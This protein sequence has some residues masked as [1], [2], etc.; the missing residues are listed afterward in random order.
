MMVSRWSS[1]SR[2]HAAASRS[3]SASTRSSTRRATS[4]A[5]VSI[6]SW[7][8][9][10]LCTW[11]A[12]SPGT[13]SVSTFTSAGTGLPAARPSRPS[14]PGSKRPASQHSEIASAASAGI[15]PARAS[16]TAR[17]PSASSIACSQA[18]SSTASRI[19]SG[20]NIGPK[21]LSDI[22]EPSLPIALQ[23]YVEA[24]RAIFVR[25]LG[26][27]R[28]AQVGVLDRGEDRVD[29]VGLFLVGKV[30]ACSHAFEQAPGKNRYPDVGRRG[31]VVGA[32]DDSRLDRQEL[33]AA[34]VVSAAAS[35][36]GEF[37]LRHWVFVASGVHVASVCVGL[38]ELQHRVGHDLTRAVID[39]ALDPDG[40]GVIW[41]DELRPIFV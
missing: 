24:Q 40:R 26:D 32:R 17:A 29:G 18:R 30:H 7:L 4:I 36:T 19:T 41:S 21:R 39:R 20:M 3:M 6:M 38:A 37:V 35:E 27:E 12:A 10:P 34:L 28:G 1:A 33:V 11:R 5:A 25:R 13:A 9:A 14:F 31:P 23:T 2:A 15:T 8:V 22:E 16:A